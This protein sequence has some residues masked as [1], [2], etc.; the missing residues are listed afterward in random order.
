[1][2]VTAILVVMKRFAPGTGSGSTTRRMMEVRSAGRQRCAGP[3]FWLCLSAMIAWNSFGGPGFR[4]E[5]LQEMDAA[6]RQA[7]QDQ[8][9]PGGVLWVEHCGNAYHKA[10]GNRATFPAQETM[11]EDTLFDLASLT[12]VVACTPA[13]M[14]LVE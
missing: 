10:F 7:I 2:G 14:L 3:L 13:V 6:I 4:T 1:M 12:K 5:K 11:T 9:C 8:N